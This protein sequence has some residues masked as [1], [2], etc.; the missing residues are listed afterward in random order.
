MFILLYYFSA[1]ENSLQ[2]KA[3]EQQHQQQ[4]Q[5]QI[6]QNQQS[7]QIIQQN[8]LDSTQPKVLQ[9]SPQLLQVQQQLQKQQSPK[10]T[11][12]TTPVKTIPPKYI[13]GMYA[14][15][16]ACGYTSNNHAQCQR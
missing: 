6:Y 15:C 5:Q 8:Q 11:V 10:A 16:V 7:Q 3:Q 1:A 13:N 14:L 9:K 4:I 2:L 12:T